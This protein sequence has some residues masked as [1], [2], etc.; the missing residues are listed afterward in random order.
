M[1]GCT[2]RKQR[3]KDKSFF[4][5]P[6]VVTRRGEKARETSKRRREKWLSKLSLLSKVMESPHARVCSDHFVNGRQNI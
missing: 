5:V 4:K 1:Y 6:S 3:E 2:N